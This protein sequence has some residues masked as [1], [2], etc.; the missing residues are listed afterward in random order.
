MDSIF[1]ERCSKDVFRLA[2]DFCHFLA[3]GGSNPEVELRLGFVC[4]R[5]GHVG[6]TRSLPVNLARAIPI[7]FTGMAPMQPTSES[8]LRCDVERCG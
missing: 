4:V 8:A 7:W 5:H 6:S 1:R 2:P 3:L